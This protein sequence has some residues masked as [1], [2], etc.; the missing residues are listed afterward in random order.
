VIC[1]DW[2]CWHQVSISFGRADYCTWLGSY[3]HG[4]VVGCR[5]RLHQLKQASTLTSPFSCLGPQ[6][7]PPGSAAM[8]PSEL[9]NCLSNGVLSNNGVETHSTSLPLLPAQPLSLPELCFRV[10]ERVSAFLAQDAP[11]RRLRSVQEQTRISLDVIQEAL[12]RYKYGLGDKILQRSRRPLNT[13]PGSRSS[14]YPTMAAK[15]AWSSSSSTCP[16]S[17]NTPSSPTQSSPF[18]RFNPCT[19]NPHIH[20]QK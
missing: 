9:S 13:I 20:L 10:H 15:T 7:R 1:P 5:V 2:W 11:T 16:P 3:F 8:L 17:T 19:S 18:L 14:Q 4:F 6:C 12:R